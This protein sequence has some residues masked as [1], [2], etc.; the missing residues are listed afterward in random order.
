M[1]KTL[2]GADRP[3]C[4]GPGFRL[5]R[6]LPAASRLECGLAR[7]FGGRRVDLRTQRPES[8]LQAGGH[9]P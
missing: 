1:T 9:G 4:P 2:W 5:L 8:L 7:I 6:V 3:P